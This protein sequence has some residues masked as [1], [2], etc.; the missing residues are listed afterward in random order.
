MFIFQKISFRIFIVFVSFLSISVYA[1]T[2]G[3]SS[4][5]STNDSCAEFTQHVQ[6][7]INFNP[8]GGNVEIDDTT[9]DFSGYAWG[10]VAGWINL[11]P[12]SSGVVLQCSGD[13]GAL[14]G[15]A[16]GSQV[17]WINFAPQ[18]GGISMNAEGE[19]DGYAWS[20][21]NGW[22]EFSCPGSSCVST[23]FQCSD[24]ETTTTGGSSFVP[25]PL[26]DACPNINGS[27]SSIPS[28]YMLVGNTCILIDVCPNIIGAQSTIPAGFSYN[29]LGNCVADTTDV[30][31]NL[32]G[33]Q[34]LVPSGYSLNNNQ[35]IADAVDMCSNISGTQTS[36]P[37]N[38]VVDTS[39]D[40][41]LPMTPVPTPDIPL[42]DAPNPDAPQ[43][44]DQNNTTNQISSDDMS[45][46]TSDAFS[47]L[48]KELSFSENETIQSIKK[49]FATDAPMNTLQLIS[50]VALA[51]GLAGMIP[52]FFRIGNILLSFLGIRRRYKPW[53]V[54]YDSA[55]KQPLDP[56]YVS[57]LD[58]TGKEIASSI[59]DL[60][61]RFGFPVSPGLYTITV[62]KT[63]YIFPSGK[64]SGRTN[65]ELYPNLYFGEQI[66][67]TE[68]G[69]V[70]TKNIPMDAEGIDWN[71]QAKKE[72]QVA[73]FFKKH[74]VLLIRIINVLYV[75]GFMTSLLALFSVQSVFNIIV[76]GLYVVMLFLYIMGLHPKPHGMLT[77]G[78]G[79]PIS[80]AIMRIFNARLQKEVAH[81]VSD[82]DGKYYCLI[83]KGEYYVTIE[84]KNPDGTY[85][86]IFTSSP[87]KATKGVINQNFTTTS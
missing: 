81:K 52:S 24:T 38:L 43:N 67:V 20:G 22:L 86:H 44:P 19:F 83:Q 50:T 56:A 46:F 75:V 55:T 78:N 63:H 17:G 40:C 14:S 2:I 34:S 71:E 35:C 41:V 84:R 29:N 45:G 25:V 3:T 23:D 16:W 9:G 6:G 36:I 60:D 13:T 54:V 1:A 65:D 11:D 68:Q 80:F 49:Y 8:T 47:Q 33:I 32:S 5:C 77:D 73:N 70:I 74:D 37:N 82:A 64:L 26:F 15:Y 69:Q 66:S 62:G 12:T 79:Y 30:C 59:T 21:S 57:L 61:G 76:V 18:G 4:N 10:D 48:Q 72:M 53:G 7:S 27:Q 42:P 51:S 31:P 85:T 28:G 39:G 58:A 87:F